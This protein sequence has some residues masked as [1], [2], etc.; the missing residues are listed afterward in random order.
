LQLRNQPNRHNY[1]GSRNP[2]VFPE[3]AVMKLNR[4]FRLACAACALLIIVPLCVW[5]G[6]VDQT[7]LD[8]DLLAAIKRSDVKR[9]ESALAAGANPNA[10]EAPTHLESL[11]I[12]CKHLFHRSPSDSQPPAIMV[13]MRQSDQGLRE[14][15]LRSLIAR[16]ANVNVVSYGYTPITDLVAT[17]CVSQREQARVLTLLIDAGANIETANPQGLTALTLACGNGFADSA[18][19]LLDRGANVEGA[20]GALGTPLQLAS[21][22]RNLPILAMLLSHYSRGEGTQQALDASLYVAR[23]HG[24]GDVAALLKGCGAR[25]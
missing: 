6:Q 11:L 13:A 20:P 4:T 10:R 14:A 25:E 12:W 23:Q 2:G 8:Q 17:P 19:V 15:I 3:Y 16:G 5:F 1:E 24:Y 21:V 7:R 9:V 18:R 22:F